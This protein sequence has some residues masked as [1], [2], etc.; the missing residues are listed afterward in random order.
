L[1][2]F[3]AEQTN[4]SGDSSAIENLQ[5]SIKNVQVDSALGFLIED[6]RLKIGEAERMNDFSVIENRQS[7]IENRQLG[8][9]GGPGSG[10]SGGA[11]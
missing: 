8:S 9:G 7:S 3:E 4:D 1:K 2:I 10:V 6:L 5:S 11:R